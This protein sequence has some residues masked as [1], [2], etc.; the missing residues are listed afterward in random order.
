MNNSNNN[1]YSP[2][3]GKI[4]EDKSV[5]SCLDNTTTPGLEGEPKSP[6]RALQSM[7]GNVDARKEPRLLYASPPLT[8]LVSWH[9]WE[10]VGWGGRVV[11]GHRHNTGKGGK[12]H[13]YTHNILMGKYNNLICQQITLSNLKQ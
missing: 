10:T 2:F 8:F 11:R 6:E 1:S 3:L 4:I 13:I 7:L 12:V 9:G 5:V